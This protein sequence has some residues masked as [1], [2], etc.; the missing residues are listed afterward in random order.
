MMPMLEN[1][2]NITS[3]YWMMLPERQQIL[4]SIISKGEK[5]K[6]IEIENEKQMKVREEF[7]SIVKRLDQIRKREGCDKVTVKLQEDRA[8]VTMEQGNDFK[9]YA[10]LMKSCKK[11]CDEFAVAMETTRATA[12]AFQ[13]QMMI[14]KEKGLL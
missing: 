9:N 5:K 7:E 11:A 2:R 4:L 10:D 14:L 8:D 1:R 6:V 3:V 12:V 13:E